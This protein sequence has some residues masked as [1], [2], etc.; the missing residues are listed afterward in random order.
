[1]TT[2][3]F[4]MPLHECLRAIIDRRHLLEAF[5]AEP[6]FDKT[7]ALEWA[8]CNQQ[9]DFALEMIH[10]GADVH[11]KNYGGT[12]FL[13]LASRHNFPE[14]IKL[15]TEKGVDL[16]ASDA[17]YETALQTAKTRGHL[18]VKDILIAAGAK[19]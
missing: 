7:R 5:M 17:N 13:H 16:S 19:Y 6:D 3:R 18:E 15:L 11:F 8:L 2:P 1:M 10:A 9:H 12:T 14:V 4:P